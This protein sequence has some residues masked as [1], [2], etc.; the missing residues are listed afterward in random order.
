FDDQRSR[1]ERFT[2]PYIRERVS[3]L[4][5]LTNR[6]L[7]RL[8]RRALVDPASLPEDMVVVARDLGPADLLDYDRSHLRAVV[9]EEGS[10][11]S[12]VAIVARALDIPVVG[13]A[14]DV[15]SRIEAGDALVVDGDNGVI[16]IR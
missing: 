9:L 8:A 12:H 15:L 14:P 1:M 3:D 16:Y 10:A 2:D 13:R 6:L 5:D 11:L 7:M 4:Q